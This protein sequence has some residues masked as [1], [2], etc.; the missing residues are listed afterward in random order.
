MKQPK[1]SSSLSSA[2]NKSRPLPYALPTATTKWEKDSKD[3][4]V[5]GFDPS[6]HGDNHVDI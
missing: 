3:L 5:V 6:S 1:G 4:R 2:G